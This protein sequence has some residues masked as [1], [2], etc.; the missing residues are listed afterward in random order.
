MTPMGFKSHVQLVN[1]TIKCQSASRADCENADCD[2]YFDDYIF[3]GPCDTGAANLSWNIFLF[4][5]TYLPIAIVKT[6]W[7]CTCLTYLGFQLDSV[8]LERKSS[9][10]IGNY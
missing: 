4:F 3:V 8:T 10:C 2:H 7:P 6:V 9:G 1:W 5:V